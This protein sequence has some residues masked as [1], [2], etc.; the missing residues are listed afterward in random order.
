MLDLP[1]VAH[2]G[3]SESSF[4]N[5]YGLI[6][7]QGWISVR[8]ECRVLF[9]ICILIAVVLIVISTALFWSPSTLLHLSGLYACGLPTGI[10]Y[11]YIFLTWPFFTTVTCTAYA[12]LIA[13]SVFCVICRLNFGKGLAEYC[14]SIRII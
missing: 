9:A 14:E 12:L 7:F 4:P 11:R 6:V 13:T 2:L 8:R 5:P 10:V 1:A 3:M